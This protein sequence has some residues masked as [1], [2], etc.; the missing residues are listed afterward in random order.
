V[1][2]HVEHQDEIEARAPEPLHGIC[3]AIAAALVKCGGMAKSLQA[4]TS[5]FGATSP[6]QGSRFRL[7]TSPT[8]ATTQTT[9]W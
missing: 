8:S 1:L 4:R 6:V 7:E 3:S 2:E 9:P 5:N